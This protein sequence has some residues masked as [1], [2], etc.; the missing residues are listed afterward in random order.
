[1]ELRH[2][3]LWLYVAKDRKKRIGWQKNNWSD[4][5]SFATHSPPRVRVRISRGTAG[6]LKTMSEKT[7]HNNCLRCGCSHNDTYAFKHA[8]SVWFYD[9]GG[10][11]VTH[12]PDTVAALDLCQQCRDQ[13]RRC[14]SRKMIFQAPLRAAIDIGW[15]VWC[16]YAVF[17]LLRLAWHLATKTRHLFFKIISMEGP[18]STCVLNGLIILLEGLFFLAIILLIAFFVYRIAHRLCRYVLR[19]RPKLSSWSECDIDYVGVA[20]LQ[21]VPHAH[22]PSFA[23]LLPALWPL[24]IFVIVQLFL[25][26]PLCPSRIQQLFGMNGWGAVVFFASAG[27]AYLDMLAVEIESVLQP[28]PQEKQYSSDINALGYGLDETKHQLHHC[29]PWRD[30]TY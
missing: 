18:T 12:H 4:Q 17:L 21:S 9:Q 16:M 11:D 15:V 2:A 5:R 13:I 23:K 6:R 3:P 10:V 7:F 29:L 19:E 22:N 8:P 1:M 25:I 24:G 20:R 30:R 26:I 28:I 27:F 14:L